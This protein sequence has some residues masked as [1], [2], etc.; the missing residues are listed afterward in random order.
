VEPD[1]YKLSKLFFPGGCSGNFQP[2]A[3]CHWSMG[4]DELKLKPSRC[5]QCTCAQKAVF[6]GDATRLYYILPSIPV[7]LLLTVAEAGTL[8]QR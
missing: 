7:F 4:L 2:G 6:G 5:K 3:L 8:R 1:R